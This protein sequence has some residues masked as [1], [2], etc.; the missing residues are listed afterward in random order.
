MEYTANDVLAEIARSSYDAD[1]E[2]WPRFDDGA[3]RLGNLRV[4]VDG[5]TL[6]WRDLGS[7]RVAGLVEIPAGIDEDDEL[8]DGSYV[9]DVIDE[10]GEWLLSWT[11]GIDTDDL[12]TVLQDEIGGDLADDDNGDRVVVENDGVTA[13]TVAT[14]GESPWALLVR[15]TVACELDVVWEDS[16]PLD[17]E[18]AVTGRERQ[19]VKE[20]YR[21]LV[22]EAGR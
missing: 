20:A 18:L 21:G 9:S 14:W 22:E 12:L 2:D 4:W 8:P 19:A 3:L 17:P 10:V 15:G 5:D 11:D 16:Y 7:P 6:V 1:L 13:W